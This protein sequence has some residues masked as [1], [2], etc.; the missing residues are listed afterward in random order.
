VYYEMSDE[1]SISF[2]DIAMFDCDCM[3]KLAGK[4]GAWTFMEAERCL[5]TSIYRVG[6]KL[7][8]VL[9]GF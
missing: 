4:Y 5:C 2:D 3:F 6:S 1:F 9:T 7:D 8:F